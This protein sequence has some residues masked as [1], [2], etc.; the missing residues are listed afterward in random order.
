M[1]HDKVSGRNI[2][3][4]YLVLKKSRLQDPEMHLVRTTLQRPVLQLAPLDVSTPHGPVLSLG[5][6]GLVCTTSCADPGRVYTTGP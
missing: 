4:L 5:L 2:N 6:P 1:L 3:N